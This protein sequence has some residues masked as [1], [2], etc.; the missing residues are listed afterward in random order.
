MERWCCC[1]HAKT[2]WTPYSIDSRTR[3]TRIPFHDHV[4]MI[5]VVVYRKV[6]LLYYGKTRNTLW[7]GGG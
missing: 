6:T 1:C 2:H 7:S 4:H 5:P 3:S